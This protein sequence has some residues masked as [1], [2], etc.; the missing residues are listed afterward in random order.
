MVN[1]AALRENLDRVQ[2]AKMQ[3]ARADLSLGG[4]GVGGV[5]GVQSAWARARARD[6]IVFL[7]LWQGRC[8]GG[9]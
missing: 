1:C 7:W 5:F 3:I 9:F 2:N 8:F 4:G 6:R